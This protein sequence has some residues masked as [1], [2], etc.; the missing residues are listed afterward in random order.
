[1]DFVTSPS[2]VMQ[3]VEAARRFEANPMALAGRIIGL[4]RDDQEAGVPPWAWCAVAF[5]AGAWAMWK[6][7]PKARSFV[8][9]L[10]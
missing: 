4:G 9:A 8:R 2:D 3:V 6:F 1:M 10:Q 5:A 7:S